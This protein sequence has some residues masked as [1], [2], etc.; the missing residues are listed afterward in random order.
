LPKESQTSNAALVQGVFLPESVSLGNLSGT[1]VIGFA[2]YLAANRDRSAFIDNVSI[3]QDATATPEPSTFV[4]W[5][6]LG[7]VGLG[8]LALRKKYCV[9]K[10]SPAM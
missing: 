3:T 6:G 4:V 1:H 8:F 10:I 7:S 5:T 9:A 2:G